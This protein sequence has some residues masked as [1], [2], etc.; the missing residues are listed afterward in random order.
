MARLGMVIDLQ[1]CVGCGACAFACKAENNTR[2]RGDGQSFNWADFVMKTEGTFPNVTHWVMP[3][4]CNH[5]TRR[6]VRR[7][8]PGH[9]EGDVQDARGH[10]DARRRAVHRLPACART[11]AR[12]ATRKLDDAS[13]NG[14]TYSVISFNAADAE[15]AA[16]VDR[17]DRADPRLHGVGRRNRARRPGATT[18]DDEPVRAGRRRS[19]CA[20]RGVVEK[21]TFCYHR[22]SQRPAAGLRRGLPVAGAHLRRPGRSEFGDRQGA[23]GAKVVPPPG[24]EGHEAERALRRQVQRPRLSCG[25]ERTSRGRATRPLFLARKPMAEPR[26]RPRAPRAQTSAACWR[27][28][29]TSPAR[30]SPRSGSSIRC[31]MPRRAIDP[32]LGGARAPPRRGIRRRR[33]RGAARRLHAPVP[34]ARPG[35]RQAV[36]IGLARGGRRPDAGLDDGG[37]RALRAR[38]DSRSTRSSASCPTTSRSSSS[39]CICCDSRRCRP[40]ETATRRR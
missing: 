9:A 32:D 37:A 20:R 21:C 5:C 26:P 22:T 34:R 19:R 12:T 17:Q 11:P 6:A 1:R 16:A 10:H 38:A 18:A 25:R 40:G 35:A 30:S 23:E 28:A 39:S 29:T 33:T 14:E 2:N 3:V 31:R 13:L 27:P 7:G 8:L 24:G 15:H 36:R 4:L